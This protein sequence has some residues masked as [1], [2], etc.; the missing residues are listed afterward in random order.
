MW[1]IPTPVGEGGREEGRKEGGRR[2]EGGRKEGVK[3]VQY[4]H[5]RSLQA[6]LLLRQRAA[7][8]FAPS[9][10]ILHIGQLTPLNGPR[11]DL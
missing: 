4:R 9:Y 7:S 10:N 11:A 8:M 6:R 5:Q 2:E 3:E 1:H